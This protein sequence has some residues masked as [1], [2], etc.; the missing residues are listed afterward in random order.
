MRGG[1]RE[2]RGL[3]EE[4]GE[5]NSE[6]CG[7]AEKRSEVSDNTTADEN[8]AEGGRKGWSGVKS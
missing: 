7:G 4:R 6:L 8:G 3:S 1:K 2:K 5:G